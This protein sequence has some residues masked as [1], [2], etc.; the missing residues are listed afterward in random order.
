MSRRSP[1][2]VETGYYDVDGSPRISY[3]D[4]SRRN[5][6]TST[7]IRPH[8][9]PLEVAVL[10]FIHVPEPA[11]QPRSWLSLAWVIV[12]L[13]LVGLVVSWVTMKFAADGDVRQ[14][15]QEEVK[16]LRQLQEDVNYLRQQ[17]A[18]HNAIVSAPLANFALEAHGAQVMT[19]LTSKTHV[20]KKA[21]LWHIPLGPDTVI[22]GH[23]Y[24]LIP[25]QCWAFNGQNGSIFIA[26]PLKIHITQVTVGHILKA[27]SLTG[28]IQSAPKSFSV[29]GLKDFEQPEVRLVKFLYDADGDSFQTFEILERHKEETFRYVRVEIHDNH[30]HDVVTCVYSFRWTLPVPPPH[31]SPAQWTLPVPPPHLS[32]AQWT[33]PVPP[34]HLSPAQ[35]TLQ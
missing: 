32:R 10:R 18:H 6:N 30:G 25:G 33:L 31:L 5:S 24:P 7:K 20:P 35:W 16:H 14:Q 3:S 13:L 21:P 23:N 26:L 17:L 4:N 34:P 22:K 27:Q 2:L 9:Q 12:Q 1:R 19:A 15:L 28:T 11:V 8:S 29:Y